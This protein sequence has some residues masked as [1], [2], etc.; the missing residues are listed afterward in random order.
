LTD[1]YLRSIV[2]RDKTYPAH[3]SMFDNDSLKGAER[4]PAL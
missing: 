4:C 1:S 3:I 2:K